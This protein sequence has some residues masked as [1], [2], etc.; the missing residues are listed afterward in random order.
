[1]AKTY[2]IVV[3]GGGPGGYVAAIKGAQLGAK[4]A[5]VEKEVVGGI[6]LNHGCIPTKTF[7][8]SAKVYKTLQHANDY[9]VTNSGTV[10]FDWDKILSRKNGVVKQLTNGVA[11]L[12]K[13]NGVDVYNGFGEVKS[14]SEVV[15]NGETLQTKNVIIATGATAVV[16]PIPGVKEAYEKGIVVTSRELLNVKDYPKSIVIVGG[17][18]IGVEFATV[19]NSFGSKVTIIE[20]MD[21]ILPTMDDDVRQAYAKTLKRDGIEILTKAEV[22]KV[23]DHKITYSFEGVETTIESD[24]ILMAVG[25]R[26]NSK[27]LEHLNLEMDRANIK[28]NEYLQTNVKGIYAIGDVN[29]KYML[30]HVAEH[31]GVVAVEHILG[32]GHQKMNYDQI[33]SCIYGSPEIAAIGL[34]EKE[35][36]ARGIDYKVSKVPLAAIGKALADGEKEGFA[37]L[38]VDKKYLEVI[39]AHIYAYNATELIS[40]YS[41]AMKAEATAYEMAHA[42]H[43]HPTLSELTLEAALGAIDKP[44][45]V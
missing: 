27:G 44:I 8:K 42:V 30:A 31:E 32:K 37:K 16:P 12:L 33:P 6:C 1:M 35:A 18:V 24:L 7:L 38:I 5:L 15:V 9:G 22:K 39:G 41:V 4:V 40:E 25:T 29:G 3:V 10:G 28:T 11:F 36:K 2:D 21:G 13:K 43:P 26:A 20:M 14:A 23:N 34:T 17:G 45:H 19:F